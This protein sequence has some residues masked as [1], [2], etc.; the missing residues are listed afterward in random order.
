MHYELKCTGSILAD[1]EEF[2][3][4]HFLTIDSSIERKIWE[5]LELTAIEKDYLAQYTNFQFDHQFN[6]SAPTINKLNQRLD[7]PVLM[8]N[9]MIYEM[10]D[11][12]LENNIKAIGQVIKQVQQ[13]FKNLTEEQ[14]QYLLSHLPDKFVVYVLNWAA[15]YQHENIL[16]NLLDNLLYIKAC[17]GQITCQWARDKKT[18]DLLHAWCSDDITCCFKK[19]IN[20]DHLEL[21]EEFHHTLPHSYI[22]EDLKLNRT[23]MNLLHRAVIISTNT[24]DLNDLPINQQTLEYLDQLP[25]YYFEFKRKAFEKIFNQTNDIQ[26]IT[27]I[28]QWVKTK[29]ESTKMLNILARFFN[30]CIDDAEKLSIFLLIFQPLL[31]PFELNSLLNYSFQKQSIYINSNNV[32]NFITF[33]KFFID[34]VRVHTNQEI[35]PDDRVLHMNPVVLELLWGIK[36]YTGQTIYNI[37]LKPFIYIL[38]RPWQANIKFFCSI[39]YIFKF[40]SFRLKGFN[41]YNFLEYYFVSWQIHPHVLQLFN[42]CLNVKYFNLK[43]IYAH[44]QEL[45]NYYKDYFQITSTFSFR[46]FNFWGYILQQGY[47]IQQ[48]YLKYNFEILMIYNICQ[49]NVGLNDEEFKKYFATLSK[50]D[51]FRIQTLQK[52]KLSTWAQEKIRNGQLISREELYEFYT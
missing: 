3:N 15:H 25:D 26:L 21:I 4:Q 52:F 34:Q 49:L 12:S 48:Y 32:Q 10:F 38:Q 11:R 43:D 7:L 35:Y 33:T 51:Q 31:T 36:I 29:C 5:E 41:S 42:I 27:T 23:S 40:P 30:I 13:C 39:N 22:F 24:F 17:K 14:F 1:Q 45:I 6:L 44:S 16:V 50:F 9:A 20:M 2:I 28:Y 46:F 8:L 47:L 19:H 37:D 18:F